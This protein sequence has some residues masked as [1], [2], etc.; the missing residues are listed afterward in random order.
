[1]SSKTS[2]SVQA[3]P[4]AAVSQV[5]VETS[6]DEIT[7]TVKTLGGKPVTVSVPRGTDIEATVQLAGVSTSKVSFFVKGEEV[8]VTTVLNESA[9]IAVV[10]D[11]EG[12]MAS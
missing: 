7:F 2:V 8:S 4:S 11:V 1:M 3:D 9:T 5:T 10:E 6:D 12:G